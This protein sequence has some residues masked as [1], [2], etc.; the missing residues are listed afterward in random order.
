[1]EAADQHH[2]IATGI[3]NNPLLTIIIP[4][5]Q[6]ERTLQ[7]ALDSLLAQQFRDFEVL[8]MDSASRDRTLAIAE[9]FAE[10]DGRVRIYSEPDKGIYD[11]MNKGIAQAR[12]QWILFL[13]SDDRLNCKDTLAFFAALPDLEVFDLVYGNVVSPSYKGVYDGAF[14]FP[15]LLSR[16][17]PH[18]AIFF[19]KDLFGLIG[20]YTIHYRGH[21]D[22]E[23][24]IRCFSDNRVRIRYIDRVVA[25]FGADGVSSRHDIPFIKERL[26]AERLRLLNADPHG[27]RST[28]TFD[29]WWRMLRNAGIR[30]KASLEASAGGQ[31]I[32]K[33]VV[34][35]LA[36]QRRLPELLLRKGIFSKCMMFINY[37]RNYLT[38]SL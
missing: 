34:S 35:M 21:A 24:N 31:P 27:L 17:M 16:N 22:W 12:G 23:F 25:Y 7:A 13:G 32:P 33:A 36:W 26:L 18:Q 15:K 19:R 4:T 9:A 38:A 1:M 5:L 29:E 2:F 14:T 8:I 10:N 28:R 11:A 3:M 20:N 37:L 30:D 6:A